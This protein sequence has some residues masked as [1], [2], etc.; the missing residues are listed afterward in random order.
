MTDI[1]LKTLQLEKTHNTR[2]ANKSHSDV[3][4]REVFRLQSF[5][6]ENDRHRF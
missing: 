5:P 3:L 2:V 6:I 1:F 4:C